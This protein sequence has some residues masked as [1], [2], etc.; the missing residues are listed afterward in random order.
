VRAVAP[1]LTGFLSVLMGTWWWVVRRA[2]DDVYGDDPPR[3]LQRVWRDHR[4]P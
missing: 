1:P 3:G 4:L 2:D